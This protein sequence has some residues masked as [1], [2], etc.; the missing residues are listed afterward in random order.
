MEDD[1]EYN[2]LEQYE[3]DCIQR[4]TAELRREDEEARKAHDALSDCIT[5]NR[6]R[7]T[8]KFDYLNILQFAIEMEKKL[9]VEQIKIAVDNLNKGWGIKS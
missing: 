5:A 4:E 3:R 6:D 8:T 2:D 7:F 9:T 1:F